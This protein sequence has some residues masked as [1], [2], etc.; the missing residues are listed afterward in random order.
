LVDAELTG[1]AGGEFLK[2]TKISGTAMIK[3]L[4]SQRTG[5]AQ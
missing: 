4:R 2:R 5:K 3:L 1:L